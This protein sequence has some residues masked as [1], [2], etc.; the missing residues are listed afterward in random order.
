MGRHGRALVPHGCAARESV[1]LIRALQL[2]CVRNYIPTMIPT[3][4][5]RALTSAPDNTGLVCK[6][7]VPDWVQMVQASP[8]CITCVLVILYLFKRV[9][10]DRVIKVMIVSNVV[11]L[12][13]MLIWAIASGLI[14][15]KK[16]CADLGIY[17]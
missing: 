3:M 15:R 2:R 5:P 6:E 16:R 14:Q 12:A 8:G 7:K 1:Q 9:A 11:A 17:D 4:I 10:C 13:V